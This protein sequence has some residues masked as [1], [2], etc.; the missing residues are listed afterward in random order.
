MT[1]LTYKAYMS[2]HERAYTELFAKNGNIEMKS[3]K[4]PFE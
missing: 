2:W 3:A 4:K 1:T